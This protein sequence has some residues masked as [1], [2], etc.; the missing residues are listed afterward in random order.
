MQPF[1][2][3][4]DNQV[5]I[6]E[7]RVGDSNISTT[8]LPAISKFDAPDESDAVIASTFPAAIPEPGKYHNSLGHS[9]ICLLVLTLCSIFTY[10]NTVSS[11]LFGLKLALIPTILALPSTVSAWRQSENRGKILLLSTVGGWT[12]VAWVM[13]LMKALR[14]NF[15][16]SSNSKNLW[17]GGRI[18]VASSIA[19]LASWA[20]SAGS[21][22]L[23]GIAIM[24]CSTA[25]AIQ[26]GLALHWSGTNAGIHQ[27]IWKEQCSRSAVKGWEAFIASYMT[28]GLFP[29]ATV[30]A[31]A[32]SLV[33]N[34]F[35]FARQTYP[36]SLELSLCSAAAAMFVW[37]VIVFWAL[38]TAVVN[39]RLSTA[40][41]QSSTGNAKPREQAFQLTRRLLPGAGFAS[42][43]FYAPL[44]VGETVSFGCV[45]FWQGIAFFIAYSLTRKLLKERLPEKKD[46]EIQQALQKLLDKR[47]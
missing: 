12:V 23:N 18:A 37:G 11:S 45:A 33:A 31:G 15:D 40:L 6:T 10:S 35:D 17:W 29:I 27:N 2:E 13:A 30:L 22:S 43:C 1:R 5:E 38:F 36:P 8:D 3:E 46:V 20:L 47:A 4:I 19:G 41:D 24:I 16:E 44:A 7:T 9:C 14:S 21:P 32:S 25:L 42:L 28:A 34:F 26:L 39:Y